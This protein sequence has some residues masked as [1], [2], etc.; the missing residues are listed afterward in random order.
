MLDVIIIT[1]IVIV[2]ITNNNNTHNSNT[3]SKCTLLIECKY[4][5]NVILC[6]INMSSKSHR[7]CVCVT[8]WSIEYKSHPGIE[9][10]SHPEVYIAVV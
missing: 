10:K 4:S 9:H 5:P 3:Y 8:H 1:I 7:M 6:S 2:I